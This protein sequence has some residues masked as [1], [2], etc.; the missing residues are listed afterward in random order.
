MKLSFSKIIFFLTLLCS[1]AFAGGIEEDSGPEEISETQELEVTNLETNLTTRED[2]SKFQD[3]S[4]NPGG[5]C[6]VTW[7]IGEYVN[8]PNFT[9]N[10]YY[11]T[12]C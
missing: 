10:L 9:D 8:D 4:D 3:L 2:I 6:I 5:N 1:V 7:G 12:W 11:A